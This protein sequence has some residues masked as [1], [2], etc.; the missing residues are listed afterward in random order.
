[1]WGKQPMGTEQ[2]FTHCSVW[3]SHKWSAI[4]A[5]ELKKYKWQSKY[6]C[7]QRCLPAMYPAK[8][9]LP[10][11]S[12]NNELHSCRPLIA[13][14][15]GANNWQEQSKAPL[16]VWYEIHTSAQPVQQRNWRSKSN[17]RSMGTCKGAFPLHI[18]WKQHHPLA[19][20]TMNCTPADYRLQKSVGQTTNRNRARL[21]SLFGMKFTHKSQARIQQ[22][23]CRTHHV[24]QQFSSLSLD[25]GTE[26][27]RKAV[28][29]NLWQSHINRHWLAFIWGVGSRWLSPKQLFL[30]WQ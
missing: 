11:G 8:A 27:W 1:V 18:P 9:A 24:T 28:L 21:P 13:E 26:K 20:Q 6:G 30:I 14:K 2:G 3:N 7:M 17:N 4:T 25:N 10:F 23:I 16:T 22:L 5:S 29:D 19:L 12:S 15:C